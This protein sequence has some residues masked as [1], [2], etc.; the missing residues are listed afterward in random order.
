MSTIKEQ[1]SNA[2]LEQN[3]RLVLDKVSQQMNDNGYVV[4][5]D[6]EVV[7]HVEYLNLNFEGLTYSGKKKLAKRI[8]NTLKKNGMASLNKFFWYLKLK[9]IITEKVKLDYSEKEKE[10]RHLKSVW[11]L[12]AKDAE[13]ARLKYVETKGDFYKK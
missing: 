7:P 1:I 11:R 9:G 3:V 10:I 6:N 13:V 4:K 8:H 12:I 5:V 2:Q